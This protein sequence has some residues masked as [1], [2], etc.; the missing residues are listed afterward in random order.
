VAKNTQ[1]EH[2]ALELIGEGTSFRA[3]LCAMI[4]QAQ[5]FTDLTRA[6]VEELALYM[7]AYKARQGA[8][9]FT[10]G[11]KGT[12]VCVVLDGRIEIFKETLGRQ[13]RLIAAVRPGKSMGEMSVIDDQPHSATAVAS[14]DTTLLLMTKHRF[15]Q[16]CQER[17]ALGIKI[18]WKLARLVSLRLRQTTGV[19]MDY[20]H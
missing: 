2:P 5:I 19:L 3:E 20:L 14:Q 16:L 15:Q 17:P 9:I 6:E 7:Q 8:Q 4:E 12:Y 1:A 10:E 13:R 18:L 11:E